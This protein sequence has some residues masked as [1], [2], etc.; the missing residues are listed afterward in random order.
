MLFASYSFL[1]AFLGSI[2]VFWMLSEGIW[3]LS[4]NNS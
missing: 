1:A 4:V 2:K 3:T